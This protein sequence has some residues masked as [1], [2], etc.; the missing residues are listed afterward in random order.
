MPKNPQTIIAN[1]TVLVPV[2]ELKG[3]DKNPRKGNVK[4]IAESLEI[5]KQY[6]PIVVQKSTKKILA[7]NHTWL[8]AQSLGWKEIAVVFVDVDD[9][10]AKRIVLADNKTND[11]ADYDGQILAELLRDLGT[12]D[13]TGYSS[14]DMD[15]ILNATAADVEQVIWASNNAGEETLSQN[16]P[17]I[18]V[19][20]EM[21]VSSRSNDEVS[22]GE[23]EDKESD[24]ESKPDD[25][26][27]VYTLKE[28][29][30][31]EGSKPWDIPYLRED[32]LIEELPEPLHTWA[33]SATR[34][35]GWEGYWLY[36]WGIDST[37]GMEDLSKIFLSFYCWDEY[38][39]PWWNNTVSHLSKVISAKIKYAITPNFSQGDLPRCLSLFALYKSRWIGR[40][41]QEIG[42]RVMPDIEAMTGVRNDKEYLSILTRSLPKRL[43]WASIQVQNLTGQSLTGTKETPELRKEW[44]EDQ[45]AIL[46][47][48]NVEN[49][50]VYVN[51]NRFAE[52]EQWFSY[53][54]APKIKCIGT[55]LYYLTQ[56]SKKNKE[57]KSRI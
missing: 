17:L 46:N 15:A 18:S 34:N 45:K 10:A 50:L 3:Y 1:E 9:V 7:G 49:L 4:A 19:S 36:N 13:G 29:M 28:E 55:R 24:I 43:P 32:M 57:D 23:E 12:A 52:V 44:L 37:S 26:T 40:Y 38:F 6:R 51:P 14:A 35:I 22:F 8:A 56:L 25:L 16:D 54:G 48:L 42:V 27:G 41:L 5:N 30:I 53:D 33:G 21:G 31:F 39:E 20:H 2:S 47:L 11:L